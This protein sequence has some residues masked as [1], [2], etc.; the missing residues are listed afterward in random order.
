MSDT[1]VEALRPV[2]AAIEEEFRKAPPTLAVIG[3]S[4]VGKSSLINAMFGTRRHVSPTVRGTS[5]FSRSVFDIVSRRVEGAPVN[6]ALQ[7]ID[8][9]GL[10]EDVAADRNYL[11]RYHK[12]LPDADIALWVIAARNRALALDQQYLGELK[13]V[14]PNLVLAINQADLVEPLSWNEAINLPSADQQRH[15]GEIVADRREKLGR[16]VGYEPETVAVSAVRFHNLQALFNACLKAAPKKR[17]WM[18]EL[19]KSFSTRDWLDRAKGLSAA[20][21]RQIAER[22]IQSDKKL[23]L[24]RLGK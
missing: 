20:Q 1:P 2:V 18:F 24:D 10:G 19:L 3:L 4:G 16:V 23:A 7:V 14:L 13:A 12:H 15:I 22:Y 9:P 21:R 17:Q 11:T 5:R 8:A 6:C